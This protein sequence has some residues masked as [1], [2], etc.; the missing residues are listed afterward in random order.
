M[1][2]SP[3]K[4]Y[5]PDGNFIAYHKIEGKKNHTGIIFLGG[6]M[7]DME[8]IKATSLEKFCKINGYPF[9]RFDYFGHGKSSKEFTDCT[10]GMWKQNVLD[11]LDR[12]TAGRQILVGSSMGGWLMLLA[13]LERPQRVAALIGIASAADF[14]EDLIWEKL[15]QSEQNKLQISGKYNLKSEYGDDPYPITMQLIEEGRRHLLL[16]KGVS[17]SENT[18]STTCNPLLGISCPVRLIHGLKDKDVP[19]SISTRIAQQLVGCDVQVNLVEDGDH[20]MST[21]ENIE[22]LYVTLEKL[23]L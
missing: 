14:T 11:V 7:S 8:G 10:I 1:E 22:F 19:S 16:R 4:L 9:I 15:P 3:Q 13:A 23:Y 2:D 20:R 18:Q 5:L 17:G 6:F 21:P 12:L